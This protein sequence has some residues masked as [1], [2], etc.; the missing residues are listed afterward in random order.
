MAPVR[1]TLQSENRPAVFFP[2][3]MV[4]NR[5][6]D[7]TATLLTVSGITY[8]INEPMEDVVAAISQMGWP[9]PFPATG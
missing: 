7:D 3:G 4:V 9:F 6:L 2:N 8:A 1:F 5:V